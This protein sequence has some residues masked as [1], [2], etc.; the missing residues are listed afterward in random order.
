MNEPSEEQ[1]YIIDN[2]LKG[3]NIIVK[4]VA[5]SGKSTTVLAL[6]KV[7]PNKKILQLTYNSNLRLENVEKVK[8]LELDNIY[9]HTFHSLGFKYYSKQ[10]HTDTG[11]RQILLKNMKPI[12]PIEKIDI[13]VIDENQDLT[14]LYFNFIIKFL[15]DMDNHIQ[16]LCLGDPRQCIYEFKGADPRYLTMA[17]KIWSN[18][19]L[20]KNKEFVDC[21]LKT[22]YRITNQMGQFVNKALIGN[23]LM[24]TCRNGEP[25]TYYRNS[26]PNIE[27]FLVFTIKSLLEEGVNPE[28]IFIL[29]ASVK[30]INSY[31]RKIE[32]RLVEKNIPCHVPIFETEKLDERVIDGKI[33]FSTFHSVK[34][35]QRPYVFIIGFDNNYFV[36][37]ARTLDKDECPNTLYVGCTRAIQQLYLIEYD[38]WPTDRPLQFMKMGHHDFKNCD[39][40]NFKGTPRSIFYNHVGEYEKLKPLI[41]KRY[42]TPSKLVQFI[43]DFVLNKIA[44]IIEEIF[45]SNR[46]HYFEINIPNVIKGNNGF[47]DVSDLNGI[48]IPCLYYEMKCKKNILRELINNA[49]IDFRENEHSYLKGII[50]NHIPEECKSIDDYLFLANIYTAIQERLYFKLKQI[51]FDQYNWLSNESINK[52][53]NRLENFVNIENSIPEFEKYIIHHSM[54]EQHEKIDKILKPYFKEDVYFRFSAIIDVLTETSVWELKCTNTITIEHKI[55]MILYAW[56]WDVMDMP[57]KEFKLLNI[58]TGEL[59]NLNYTFDQLTQIVVLILKGK[60]EKV[61]FK[62]DSVFVNDSID[63]MNKTAVNYLLKKTDELFFGEESKN[64]LQL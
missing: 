40:V 61:E 25:V 60:Y 43:P 45:I 41:D 59:F 37:Y 26:R 11:L 51:N 5:G 1:Q 19:F 16:V 52:C 49:L 53:L 62:T 55:Q 39:F 58:K 29:A 7:C 46:D 10:A 47:E 21:Q 28:D 63:Y 34:G 12:L 27:I 23:E 31:I 38:Q 4:A 32:N 56:L 14:E 44:P 24:L 36:Q 3:Y 13:L 8:K 18:F 22:S 33:V 64:D 42:E 17:E 57:K 54:E 2:V 48:A 15:M 20:L 30:G 6:S 35:R 9:V 50:N